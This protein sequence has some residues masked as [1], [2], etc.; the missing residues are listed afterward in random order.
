[1][2]DEQASRTFS[3]DIIDIFPGSPTGGLNSCADERAEGTIH[4]LRCIVEL[5]SP[6]M[7][8]GLFSYFPGECTVV[9]LQMDCWPSSFEFSELLDAEASIGK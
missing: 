8:T 4:R 5:H 1:M 7:T 6:S 2:D 9:R 3:S